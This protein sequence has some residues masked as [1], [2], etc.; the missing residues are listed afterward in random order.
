MDNFINEPEEKQWTAADIIKE[1]EQCQDKKAVANIYGIT[2]GEV[3]KIL[4]N[5]QKVCKWI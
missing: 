4:K 1:F 3:S 5:T 2:A